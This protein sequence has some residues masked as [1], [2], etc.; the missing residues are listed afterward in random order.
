MRLS[1]IQ[2]SA[3]PDGLNHP[4][5]ASSRE[6]AIGALASSNCEDGSPLI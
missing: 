4:I 1:S 2:A 6:N 3:T 5:A